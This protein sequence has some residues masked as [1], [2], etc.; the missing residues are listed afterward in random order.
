[1]HNQYQIKN[2]HKELLRL[3][4]NHRYTECE[5]ELKGTNKLAVEILGLKK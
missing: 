2:D 5:V 4:P 1:M 3:I